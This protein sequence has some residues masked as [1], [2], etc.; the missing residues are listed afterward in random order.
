MNDPIRESSAADHELAARNVGPLGFAVLTLS[1]T[2]TA[3]TDVSGRT[4]REMI[5]AAGHEV[6]RYEVLPDDPPRIRAALV[7]ALADPRVAVVVSNGGTGIAVRDNAYEVVSALLD[8]PLVGFG[9]LFRMLSW[10]QVGA[11]AM[12]SRATAGIARGKVVFA[13]PGSTNAVRLGM[14]KLIVPEAAHL[15]WE[16]HKEVPQG[17]TQPKPL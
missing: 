14:E 5:A 8:K 13:L 9:E 17:A 12:L 2:R 1:D 15:Y 7:E 6:A 4:I 3:E 11:A 16:L 10:E